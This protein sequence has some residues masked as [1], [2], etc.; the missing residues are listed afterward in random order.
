MAAAVFDNNQNPIGAL[1][2]TG[3]ESRFADRESVLGQLLLR[4]AHRLSRSL[5]K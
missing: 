3:I 2:L 4:H 5:S 1:T